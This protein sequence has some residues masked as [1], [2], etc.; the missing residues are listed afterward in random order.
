MADETLKVV[1]G[2]HLERGGKT[3]K[4]AGQ[5]VRH[6]E[7]DPSYFLLLVYPGSYSSRLPVGVRDN[8]AAYHG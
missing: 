3:W 8:N 1:Y 6:F 2:K 7:K 5:T 4:M